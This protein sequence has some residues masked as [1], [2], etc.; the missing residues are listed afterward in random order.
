MFSNQVNQSI[1]W[2]GKGKDRGVLFKLLIT[3]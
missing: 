1:I 2:G 3:A